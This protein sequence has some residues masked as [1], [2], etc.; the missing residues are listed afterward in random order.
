[1]SPKIMISSQIQMMNRKIQSMVKKA[2]SNGYDVAII[3]QPFSGVGRTN[4]TNH[5]CLPRIRATRPPSGD[6]PSQVEAGR[7]RLWPLGGPWPQPY[8]PGDRDGPAE[9]AG[10]VLTPGAAGDHVSIVYRRDRGRV[11]R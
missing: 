1:M 2:S 7:R 9:A 8:R 3:G 10:V 6:P 11:L 4:R 5:T